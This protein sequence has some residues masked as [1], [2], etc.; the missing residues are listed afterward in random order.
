MIEYSDIRRVIMSAPLLFCAVL[1]VGCGQ[2]PENANPGPAITVTVTETPEAIAQAGEDNPETTEKKPNTW[3]SGV[4]EVDKDIPPGKYRTKIDGS[5]D[6]PCYYARL[7]DLDGGTNSIIKNDNISGPGI[8]VISK[9]DAY[10]E[11]SGACEWE[12]AG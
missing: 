1:A 7:R 4:Y 12:K 10:I 6:S 5:D 3:S 9:A 8:L 2:S 11:L